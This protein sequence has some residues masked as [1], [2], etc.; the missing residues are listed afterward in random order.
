MIKIN[1]TNISPEFE[2]KLDVLKIEIVEGKSFDLLYDVNGR[3]ILICTKYS[4]DVVL[5]ALKNARLENFETKGEINQILFDHNIPNWEMICI[6][7]EDEINEAVKG[8]VDQYMNSE[9]KYDLYDFL[10]YDKNYKPD[11]SRKF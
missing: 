7:N 4:V 8:Y 11:Y 6:G 9:E 10:I 2:R 3:Y 1:K 5:K